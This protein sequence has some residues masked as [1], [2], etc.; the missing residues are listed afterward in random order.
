MMLG[1]GR[2]QMTIEFILIVVVILILLQTIIVPFTDYAKDS[3][4]DISSLSYVDQSADN[5]KQSIEFVTMN[6]SMAKTQVTVFIPE[7]ANLVLSADAISYFIELKDAPKN[8][9]CNNDGLCTKT[10]Y[11][12]KGISNSDDLILPGKKEYSLNIFKEP[13]GKTYVELLQ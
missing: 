2:G 1:K 12:Q 7:D 4:T 5:L 9:N 11:L 3:V 8:S 6:E 13:G 10:I